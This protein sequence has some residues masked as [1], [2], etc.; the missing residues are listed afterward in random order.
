LTTIPSSRRTPSA[1]SAGTTTR[2]PASKPSGTAGPASYRN[3]WRAVRSTTAVPC[4]TSSI[5]SSNSPGR[6]SARSGHSS[7]S[8]SSAASGFPGTPRGSSSQNAPSSASGSANHAASGSQHSATGPS[9]SDSNSGHEASKQVAA[10]RHAGPPQPGCSASSPVPASA[11]G[12]TT[13]LHHGIAT[14]LASGPASEACPNSTAVS[15]SRPRVATHCAARKPPTTGWRPPAGRHQTSQATPAKL[16]Q[17]PAVSTA[18]G[19][20]SSSAIAASASES[21]TPIGRRHN[22]ASTT[23]ATISTVRTVGSAKPATA[24]Y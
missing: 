10:S 13:R 3:A 24:A 4:P 14:R 12:T 6:G 19:S 2:S 7:G 16:S 1:C 18:S 21:P 22:R 5:T 17:K 11:S 20:T 9:A 15:G 23:I 8:N